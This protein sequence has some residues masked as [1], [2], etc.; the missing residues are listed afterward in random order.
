MTLISKQVPNIMSST[1]FLYLLCKF[2]VFN[3]LFLVLLIQLGVS[4]AKNYLGIVVEI[5][6]H[7]I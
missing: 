3:Q 7:F 4:E 6:T 2:K 5:L 1:M